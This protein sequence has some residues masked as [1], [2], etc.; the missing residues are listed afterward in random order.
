M[1]VEAFLA[2]VADKALGKAVLHGLA[3]CELVPADGVFLLPAPDSVRRKLG[4]VDADHRVWV[5]S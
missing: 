3:R 5:A 1:F 2:Q 4:A